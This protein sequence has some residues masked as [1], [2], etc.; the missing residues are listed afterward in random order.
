MVH[1]RHTFKFGVDISPIHEVL[2]NL[3]QGGGIY[4]YTSATAIRPLTFQAWTADLYNLPLST[5]ANPAAHVGKHYNTFAQA[6]DPITGT[7][8]DDFY[9]V[10]Y[11]FYGEDTWKARSN[12]TFNL[13]LALRYSVGAAT[14]STKH[15][16]ALGALTRLRRSTSIKPISARVSESRGSSPQNTVVRGGYGIFYGKT[17]NSSFYDTRVENG[18]YQQTFNCN[19]NYTSPIEPRHAGC[20]RSDFPECFVPSAWSGSCRSVL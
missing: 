20:L 7:G 15:Q 6:Y 5:D 2:I 14:A 9:D 16:F 4:S 1:N 11:G 8:K 3:F 18:V 13:G 12:L 17:T 10:D 19:A